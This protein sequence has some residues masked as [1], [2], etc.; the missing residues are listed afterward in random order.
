MNW[1]L[2][3]RSRM[4]NVFDA[5]YTCIFNCEKFVQ[6]DIYLQTADLNVNWKDE[7]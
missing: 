1:V 4:G 7:T 3:R 5:M 2:A 6:D